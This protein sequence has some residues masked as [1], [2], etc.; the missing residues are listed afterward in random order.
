MT[1]YWYPKD[2][3]SVSVSG[4]L[5][6]GHIIAVAMKEENYKMEILFPVR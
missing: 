5:L 1:K 3:D 2:Y 6:R 4:A